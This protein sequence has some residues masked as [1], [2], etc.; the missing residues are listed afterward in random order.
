MIERVCYL[1]LRQ[2]PID[3]YY[4]DCTKAGGYSRRCKQ[5]DLKKRRDR[6][7]RAKML[8]GGKRIIHNVHAKHKPHKHHEF[9]NGR[10]KKVLPIRIIKGFHTYKPI[11]EPTKRFFKWL[12]KNFDVRDSYDNVT[13]DVN[14][15]PPRT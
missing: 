8:R 6:N 13:V 2:L 14:N 7:F 10:P 12:K 15:V 1:C 4:K 9:L 11:W 3:Q 5:C